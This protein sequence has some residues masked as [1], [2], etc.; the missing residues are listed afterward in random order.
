MHEPCRQKTNVA[1]KMNDN[2]QLITKSR[3]IDDLRRL[4]V[5]PAM[6]LMV[7]S[8]LSS[9]GWV[10]G[11]PQA[12]IEALQELLGPAGTLV[13]PT[14]SAQLTDPE[15]WEDPPVPPS[16][17]QIIRDEMP[18]YDRSM[19][20]TRQ[21]G[22]IPETFRKAD[23]VRRSDH[24]NT[25]FAAWGVLRDTIIDAHRL[26][27]SMGEDSPLARLYE[28]DA[29]IL[30]LGVGHD[31][32]TSI[33]LAEYRWSGA[34]QRRLSESAPIYV[35]GTPRWVEY[36]DIDHRSDDFP[37]IGR[38][39]ARQHKINIRRVG[40]AKAQLLSQRALVDFAVE[41]LEENRD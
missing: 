24:P 41:W 40:Q 28:F 9:L 38:A 36:S 17:W 30:L 37:A 27:D 32:N 29:T 39:F 8:S 3:L 4:G 15:D 12:V 22:V 13:M 21:M 31:R 1:K 16:W 7:H 20:P 25:S 19:T 26:D 6:V 34:S 2:R 23:G 18:A 10:C 5:K 14:H 11:G 33:H 35:D